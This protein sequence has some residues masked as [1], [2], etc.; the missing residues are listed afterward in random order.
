MPG[1]LNHSVSDIIRHLLI[2]LGHGTLPSEGGLWPIYIDYEPSSPDNC[3]TVYG[4]VGLN[5]GR[6]MTDGE[7]QE[8][9]GFQIRVRSAESRECY[10]KLQ[11]IAISLDEEVILETVTVDNTPY[12]IAAVTRT[13]DIGSLGKE[14]V[15]LTKRSIC[16]VD[17]LV[18]LRRVI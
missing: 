3:I 10:I 6:T 14:E 8:H 13:S 4:I 5:T 7:R 16:V 2:Q 15:P 17:G 12:L 11:G 9:Q 1:L 18:S